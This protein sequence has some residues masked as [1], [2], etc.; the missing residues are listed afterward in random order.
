MA[1]IP[2]AIA[3]PV[4][5]TVSVVVL[6]GALAGADPM[7][8]VLDPNTR[9][10]PEPSRLILV[11]PTVTTPPGVSVVP[12]PRMY[13]VT[14]FDTVAE[15]VWPLIVS[16]GVEPIPRLDVC[17]FITT[18]P[19]AVEGRENVVPETTTCPPGVR[20]VPGAMTNCV[21]PPETDAVMGWP[22]IV[23]TAG[24]VMEGFEDPRMDVWPLTMMLEPVG[25]RLNV[26]PEITAVPPGVK[27]AP[28]PST[29]AV[30]EPETIAVMAWPLSVSTG[31]DVG[32][33]P[34]SVCVTPFNTAILPPGARLSVVPLI[35]TAGPPGV[36]VTPGEMTKAPDGFAVIGDPPTVRTGAPGWLIGTIFVPPITR[37]PALLGMPIATPLIVAT[38]PGCRVVPATTAPPFDRGV[39]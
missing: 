31:V 6:A 33:L 5:V 2:L 23:S 26:V 39:T 12:G 38:C 8:V 29:K 14:P 20:V 1:P 13:S 34:P 24:A 16:T 4:G 18:T 9:A 11:P 15:Y 10:V 27:V 28:G 7:V 35:V 30:D 36:R 37:E 22:F 25:G 32:P 3:L 19:V 21:E 17:P